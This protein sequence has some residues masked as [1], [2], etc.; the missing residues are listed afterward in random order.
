VYAGND[1]N[2]TETYAGKRGTLN[3]SDWVLEHNLEKAKEQFKQVKPMMQC[4]EKWFGPY[5]FYEDSFKLVET[6]HLGMEHQSAVAYGNHYQNGYL[7]NDLSGSGWGLKWDFILIHET[8]HEWWGN[9]ITTKDI[10]DMWVHE[11]FTSYS[12]SIYTECRFGKEA[13]VEYTIGL[14]NNIQNDRP[15]IGKYG[16]NHEGSGDMYYK[17]HNMLH[18]IRHIIDDDAIWKDIL[19]GLHRDFFH[20]IV[21]SKQIEDYINEKVE[22]DLAPVFD[23]YL[24]TA[25][26]PVF[27]YYIEDKK[28]YFR[29][30]SEVNGFDMPVR[31]TLQDDRY[32]F[33]QPE[34]DHWKTADLD[35]SNRDSFK[36]DKNF[37]VRTETG[38]WRKGDR[39]Q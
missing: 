3:L 16:V 20:Q 17:G 8:A 5:P 39:K 6:P 2:V 31:V 19:L 25:D 10:A 35:L 33:I 9:S 18:T 27:Q 28:L 4:F 22:Y 30:D 12:E 26:I 36:V 11:G 38:D 34:A 24:R 23:Q 32:S 21:T 14:R 29:W 37:Y 15:V 13:A 7:G 1:V